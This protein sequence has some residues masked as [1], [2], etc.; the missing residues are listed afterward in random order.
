VDCDP[1]ECLLCFGTKGC[2]NFPG[3]EMLA[4]FD[5]SRFSSLS[6]L[7]LSLFTQF[8]PFLRSLQTS[9]RE[10]EEESDRLRIVALLPPSLMKEH[11]SPSPP[12]PIAPSS[13][14]SDTDGKEKENSLKREREK[15]DDVGVR[16][17]EPSYLSS[18]RKGIFSYLPSSSFS[19]THSAHHMTHHSHLTHSQSLS[20]SLSL[21]L[22]HP[23]LSS[24]PT[25]SKE[26]PRKERFSEAE[27]VH[28]CR[29]H[30]S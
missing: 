7:S 4:A 23:I 29:D 3:D 21:S 20:L 2:R 24:H 16:R 25:P 13:N 8:R 9:R 27:I 14:S 18:I 11:L 15:V 22:S 10:R 6:S 26:S 12:P 19:H 5:S 28:K 17:H 30:C 1:K